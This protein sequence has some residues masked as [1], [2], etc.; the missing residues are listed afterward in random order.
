MWNTRITLIGSL[1]ALIILLLFL[2]LIHLEQLI[3]F[4][5]AYRRRTNCFVLIFQLL[6]CIRFQLIIVYSVHNP[7]SFSEFL[8]VLVINLLRNYFWRLLYLLLMFFEISKHYSIIDLLQSFQGLSNST[9]PASDLD[10][11]L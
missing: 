2:I 4:L 8:A 7:E 3:K 9:I 1:H 10:F 11:L 5:G 6:A